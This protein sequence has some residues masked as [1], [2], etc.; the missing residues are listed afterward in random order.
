VSADADRGRA[1]ARRACPC[2]DATSAGPPA[3][4]H[5]AVPVLLNVLAATEEEAR[6]APS[7]RLALVECAECGAVFN[8]AF[9]GVPYGPDYF[10]DPTR[11]ARYRE[12][13]DDV[14]D[15]VAARMEGRSSFSVVDV[16]AGQG[17][18]LAHLAERLGAR[19]TRGHGFDPAFRASETQLPSNVSVTPTRL[20]AQ[21]AA[22]LAF[23]VDVVVTRHVVEHVTDPVPFLASP[24]AW[25]AAPFMLVVETPNVGHTL[26]GGLLHD[27]CYEHCTMLGETALAAVLRRAGYEHVRVEHA[28]SG[29]YLLAFATEPGTRAPATD[30][31]AAAAMPPRS[32]AARLADVAERFVPEHRERLRHAR[33]RGLVALWGGAGKGAL[34]AHLVDPDRALIDVVVDIHPSKQGRYLPGTGHRVVAPEEALRRS[35]RTVFV[36][37]PT[38]AEEVATLCDAMGFRAD[39]ECVGDQLHARRTRS[40]A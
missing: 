27:F 25:L 2:C 7:A 24:R 15:R 40:E 19:M 17:S 5:P 32:A 22:A 9:H 38:Y 16:G 18:F 36:A 1:R 31:G 8:E 35:V 37:N 21:S 3:F 29:E 34:F 39:I 28:F 20:D 23:T 6:R 33:A 14:S 11:S 12:H 13:L 10:V 4:V 30:G 26:D